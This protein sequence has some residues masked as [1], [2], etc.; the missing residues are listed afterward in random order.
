VS[1]VAGREGERFISPAMQREKV[2]HLSAAHGHTIV[3]WAE[4]LDQPGSKLERPGLQAALE[5]IEAGAA[6][7]LIVAKL[8]RFARSM[9]D[10]LSA[11]ERLTA[12]GGELI[13]VEDGFDSSTS[14]GRFARDLLL[15]LGELELDRIRE[16]WAEADRRAV[17]RGVHICKVPPAGYRRGEDGRLELDPDAAPVV[18]EVFRRR[19]D[20]ATWSD[21]CAFLDERLPRENGGGWPRQTVSSLV[22]RR[23]YLGEGFHGGVVNLEAHPALVTRAEWEAAQQAPRT[24]SRARDGGALLAGLIRCSGCDHTLTRL[25]DGARGYANYRCRIRHSSGVCPEPTGISVTRANEYVE[26]EF[27]ARLEREPVRA[28]GKPADGTLEQA[29][30][31]LEAAEAELSAYQDAN[32]ISLIGREAFVSGVEK[33]QRAIDK[34]RERLGEANET[35]IAFDRDLLR[36]WPELSVPERRQLLATALERVTVSRS[37]GPGRGTPAADRLQLIWR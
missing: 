34:A 20:G 18:R 4:D 36:L 10:A 1:R 13:S 37:S 9:V 26:A 7:G 2:E 33:R 16:N 12:A 22:G 11:I 25:S 27:L 8:D 32:L 35:T 30:A 5:M 29:V 21:L 14:M 3:A 28:A 24:A 17:E 23:T 15:R 19:A 31:E 6:D